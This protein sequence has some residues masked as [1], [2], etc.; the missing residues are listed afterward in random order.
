MDDGVNDEG[1]GYGRIH[2]KQLQYVVDSQCDI[3]TLSSLVVS[4]HSW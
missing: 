2:N 1:C 4:S 3:L